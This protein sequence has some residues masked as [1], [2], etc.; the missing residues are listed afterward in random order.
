MDDH[1]Y[2]LPRLTNKA[3]VI[4]L[5]MRQILMLH[6]RTIV[7]RVY[8]AD[9]GLAGPTMSAGLTMKS[10]AAAPCGAASA[11]TIRAS[12]VYK[13]IMSWTRTNHLPLLILSTYRNILC[14]VN[15]ARKARGKW[16]SLPNQTEALQVN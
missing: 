1:Y 16:R 2:Q 12:F 13:N 6:G 5:L 8:E 7:A 9:N 11:F 14:V 3:V 10:A 4:I 15:Y